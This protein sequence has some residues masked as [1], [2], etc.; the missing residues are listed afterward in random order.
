MNHTSRENGESC[1]VLQLSMA[2]WRIDKTKSWKIVS[3]FVYF[4]HVSDDLLRDHM[5]SI[6]VN[7]VLSYHHLV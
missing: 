7:L 1:Q 5:W 3:L 2:K 6:Y 4:L